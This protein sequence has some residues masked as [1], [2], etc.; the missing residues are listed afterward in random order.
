VAEPLYRA[1]AAARGIPACASCHGPKG[2]GQPSAGYPRI[3]GQH[4]KYA[5]K[6]LRAYKNGE[7]SLGGS[8]QMM[9]AVAAKLSDQ[10]IDALASYLNGLQ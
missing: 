3:G 8:G 4:A 6:Q 10:E 5:A 1:G 2:A 7:R 9:A